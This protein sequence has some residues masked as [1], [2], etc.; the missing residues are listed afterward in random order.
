[1]IIQSFY[2]PILIYVK[3]IFISDIPWTEL[4]VIDKWET[5]ENKDE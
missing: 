2:R 1:M 5:K 4:L 3:S